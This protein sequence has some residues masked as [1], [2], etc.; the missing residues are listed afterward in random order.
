MAMRECG[1]MIARKEDQ[2]TDYD[3]QDDEEEKD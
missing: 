2:V 1:G 3:A